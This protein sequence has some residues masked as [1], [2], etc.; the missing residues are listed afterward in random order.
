MTVGD[1]TAARG[2]AI[3]D[4]PTVRNRTVRVADDE[5]DSS[6]RTVDLAHRVRRSQAWFERSPKLIIVCTI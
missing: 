3:L 2:T 6:W 1:V 5:C 4:A